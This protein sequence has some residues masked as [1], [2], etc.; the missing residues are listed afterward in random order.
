MPT[1]AFF[2]ESYL[3]GV[4]LQWAQHL[5]REGSAADSSIHD[6]VVSFLALAD[7]THKP[8][9]RHDQARSPLRE[10]QT[11]GYGLQMY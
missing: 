9:R 5:P 4:A 1:Y 7:I 3:Y 8:A 2:V 6:R 10:T 11:T